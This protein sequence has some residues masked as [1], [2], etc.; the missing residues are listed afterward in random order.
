MQNLRIW[1]AK[2][3]LNPKNIK[4]I[5]HYEEVGFILG[6]QADSISKTKSAKSTTS[7]EESSQS[8]AHNDRM[9]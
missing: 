6:I 8:K 5:T 2:N 7:E 3:K 1:R 9:R 4:L